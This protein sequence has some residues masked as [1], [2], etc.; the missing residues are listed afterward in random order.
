MPVP[1]SSPIEAP[2]TLPEEMVVIPRGSP[3]LARGDGGNTPNV[4]FNA[5]QYPFNEDWTRFPSRNMVL[6]FRATDADFA[7]NPDVPLH[8]NSRIVGCPR[9]HYYED[10]TDD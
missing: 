10:E 5:G 9:E 7:T 1:A 4:T 2:L 6:E 8:V 3:N